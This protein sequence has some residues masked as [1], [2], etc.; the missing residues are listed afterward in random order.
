MPKDNAYTEEPTTTKEAILV[1]NRRLGEIEKDVGEILT[2][3]T[4]YMDRNNERVGCLEL[5][6]AE[7]KI[8][9]GNIETRM[10]DQDDRIDKIDSRAN[11]W[12]GGNTFMAIIAWILAI[13]K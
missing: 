1:V 4:S 6:Q 11:L 12:G 2:S 10:S 5:G 9:I 13:F 8:T 7:R 3:I